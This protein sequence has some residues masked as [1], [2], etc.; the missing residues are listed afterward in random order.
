M[1]KSV[2]IH[3][4]MAVVAAAL[5][6]VGSAGEVLADE[7]DQKCKFTIGPNGTTVECTTVEPGETGAKVCVPINTKDDNY[8]ELELCDDGFAYPIA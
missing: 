6:G 7:C 1:K 3:A 2:W 5:M 4:V 8:C